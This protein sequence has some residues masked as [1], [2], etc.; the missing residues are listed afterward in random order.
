M[1]KL[2]TA[3]FICFVS[4][5]YS[6]GQANFAIKAGANL[7]SMN[8]EDEFLEVFNSNV[9]NRIGYQFGLMAQLDMNNQVY[10][11]PELIYSSKGYKVS[12]N[13]TPAQQTAVRY[14]YI[15]LPVLFGYNMT[16]KI[17][18][19][20]GPQ[21]GI[22]ASVYAKDKGSERSDNLKSIQDYND[23]D[24]SIGAGV[25]YRLNTRIS[26]DIRYNYGFT[27]IL[28]AVYFDRAENEIE[29]DLL[30]NNKSFEISI[31]Y[32]LRTKE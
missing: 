4:I 19:F 10:V 18:A 14:N 6:L 13:T 16:P 28:H 23:F 25:N 3:A 7:S 17:S 1:K 9:G 2:L 5:H 20:L 30:K 31:N 21:F 12:G 29:S 15:N 32:S 8:T 24:F 26:A 22:L 11:R 27:T